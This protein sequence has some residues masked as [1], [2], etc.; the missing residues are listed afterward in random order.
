MH[1]RKGRAD[2][3]NCVSDGGKTIKKRREKKVNSVD[4][5]VISWRKRKIDESSQ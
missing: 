4:P 2:G 3:N 5:L 1:D